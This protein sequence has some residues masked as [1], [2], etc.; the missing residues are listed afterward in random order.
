MK[1]ILFDLYK[2]QPAGTS[3]FHGGG[4]Y[5]KSVY[6]ELITSYKDKCKLIVFYD[7]KRFLDEWI[8]DSLKAERI[9][10]R[11]VHGITDIQR[12]LD[13]EKYDVFYAGIPY[14]Y[15][16]LSYKE[17]II[18]RGTVHGLRRVEDPIDKYEY[19]YEKKLSKIVKSRI[20]PYTRNYIFGKFWK[21]MIPCLN[22]LDEIVTVSN[23][24]KYSIEN[25]YPE[26]NKDIN[27]FYCPPGYVPLS[28]DMEPLVKEKYL[29][30]IGMNRAEKNGYRA[31]VALDSLFEKG[32]LSDLKVVTVGTI[33][34]SVKRRIK[35]SE[36]LIEYAYVDSDVLENLYK[37]CDFFMYPSINEGFGLPPLEVMRYGKT[38]IVSG[39]CSLPEVCGDAAY[40]FNPY[41]LE[42]MKNR[43]LMAYE[44]KIPEDIVLSHIE[45]MNTRRREDLKK[46]CEFIIH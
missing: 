41:D 38:C 21:D 5:I 34:E 29:L 28:E 40:Y 9:E 15:G 17:G 33:P 46:L 32:K 18:K 37:F 14:D 27:V 10:K 26:L 22:F 13:E 45:E 12:L 8:L 23:H 16:N 24:T 31:L 36:K 39:V 11:I 43:V 30:M 35:H 7:D 20:K 25:F 4:E 3:K 6:K 42:E 19:L 1:T 2:S 44:Q